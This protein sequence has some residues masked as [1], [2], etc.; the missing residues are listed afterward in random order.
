MWVILNRWVR[1]SI[2]GLAHR[3][4][5]FEQESR[6]VETSFGPLLVAVHSRNVG[7][8]SCQSEWYTCSA[9]AELDV[10]NH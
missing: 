9:E 5:P 6:G 2:E 10:A 8:T 4:T 7:P 3:S 1:N